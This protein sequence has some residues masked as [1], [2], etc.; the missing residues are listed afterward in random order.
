MQRDMEP[1]VL[2]KD[3]RKLSTHSFNMHLEITY[4]NKYFHFEYKYKLEA[5][6][7]KPL[8][9]GTWMNLRLLHFEV[10]SDLMWAKNDQL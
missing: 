7:V 5:V 1:K 8:M 9:E 4:W 2:L 6:M 3:F 10:Q